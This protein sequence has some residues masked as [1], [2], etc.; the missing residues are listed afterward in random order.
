MERNDTLGSVAAHSFALTAR[1]GETIL[2]PRVSL[3]FALGYDHI[4]LSARIDNRHTL[5]VNMPY[6]REHYIIYAV[7]EDYWRGVYRKK[8]PFL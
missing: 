5:H 6:A 3:R 7:G 1:N 8:V 4:G 2:I